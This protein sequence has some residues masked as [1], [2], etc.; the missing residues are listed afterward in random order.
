MEN[1]KKNA[2]QVT[3]EVQYRDEKNKV[4]LAKVVASGKLDAAC[5]VSGK[6]IKVTPL[7]E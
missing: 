7:R 6:V 3:F 2:I 1:A 4:R 5:K